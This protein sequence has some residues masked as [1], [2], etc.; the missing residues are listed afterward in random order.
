MIMKTILALWLMCPTGSDAGDNALSHLPS[1]L[2]PCLTA[3]VLLVLMMTIMVM[4]IMKIMIV[5]MTMMV[6]GDDDDCDVM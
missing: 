3:S 1:A 6:V 5:M 2:S 4:M